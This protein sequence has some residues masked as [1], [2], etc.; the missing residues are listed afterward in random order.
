VTE[1]HFHAELLLPLPIGELF[2]FFA[3][4]RNL[5]TLTPPWLKFEVLTPPPITL[6]AGALID[7]RIRVH[8]L[9]IRWRTEIVEWDPPHRF[10]DVQL[11]G[12]YQLWHHTHTFEGHGDSTLCRDDVRYWPRGGAIIDRLFVRRDVE[13]IFAFRQ[14]KLRELFG[15]CPQPSTV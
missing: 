1:T 2:P 12:P 3:E 13:R 4:A 15:K 14:R 7:Y 9:P 10:V 8:G 6:R 11:R 5:E